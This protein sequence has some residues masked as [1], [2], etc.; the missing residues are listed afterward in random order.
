M[1][2][3]RVSSENIMEN[4]RAVYAMM[5]N[6]QTIKTVP[7]GCIMTPAAYIIYKGVNNA[8]EEREILSFTT[9]EGE[10]YATISATFKKSFEEMWELMDGEEFSIMVFHGKS[11]KGREFVDCRM[12]IE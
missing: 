1:Q 10:V 6:A 8:G 3:I 4:K 9:K 2:I 5:H 7:D 11:N 12:V